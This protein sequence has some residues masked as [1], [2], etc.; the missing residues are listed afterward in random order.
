MFGW[1]W[2][3]LAIAAEIVATSSLKASD[4]FS[5]IVPSVVVI[6]GY[7][8]SFWLFSLALKAGVPIGLSYA[9]WSG[10]GT[11]GI[12]LV[13]RVVYGEVHTA[14]QYAGAAVVLGGVAM[15]VLGG[16]AVE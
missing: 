11:I 15:M 12:L 8:T 3:L 7:F 6:V 5:K 1:V 2:M 10:V 4:G 13:G 14:L 9:V 16:P